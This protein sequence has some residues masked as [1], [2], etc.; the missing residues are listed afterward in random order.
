MRLR[1]DSLPIQRRTELAGL[2]QPGLSRPCSAEFAFKDPRFA[3]RIQGFPKPMERIGRDFCEGPA[4]GR[5]IGTRA[6]LNHVVATAAADLV[7]VM[8]ARRI[9][10]CDAPGLDRRIPDAKRRAVH[11]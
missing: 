5:A 10:P 9:A 3:I 8:I 4:G 11:V 2:S 6:D 1:R 7:L